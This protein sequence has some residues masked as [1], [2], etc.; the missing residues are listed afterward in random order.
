MS[1]SL[2]ALGAGWTPYICAAV[3]VG[4]VIAVRSLK[5]PNKM[6][7]TLSN[8]ELKKERLKQLNFDPETFQFT[9]LEEWLDKVP[10]K[11]NSHMK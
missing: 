7:K 5:K 2:D 11:T 9:S 3:F 8:R 10:T 1:F 4:G 6:L